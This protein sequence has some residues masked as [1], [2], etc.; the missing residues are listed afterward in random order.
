MEKNTVEVEV[1]ESP[2]QLK[3]KALKT[4]GKFVAAANI[5]AA[6]SI[7]LAVDHTTE[8]NGAFTDGNT[9]VGAAVAGVIALVAIVTGLGLIVG[10]L[11]R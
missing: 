6:S 1:K 11:R 9:N 4:A 2:S 10:I 5:A 8:I 3:K 7:A